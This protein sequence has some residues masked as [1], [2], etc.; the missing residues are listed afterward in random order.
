MIAG[1]VQI[2]NDEFYL[3]IKD[4][5]KKT[6]YYLISKVRKQ[7]LVD[8]NLTG[9]AT[10]TIIHD[11]A[12]LTKYF[13]EDY[14]LESIIKSK[15]TGAVKKYGNVSYLEQVLDAIYYAKSYKFLQQDIS[16]NEY[17]L[18]LGIELLSFDASNS[19]ISFSY[20]SINGIYSLLHLHYQGIVINAK[21][22]TIKL[23]DANKIKYY[24]IT[25]TQRKQIMR[26]T[27]RT[28]TYDILASM[29]DMTWY[30]DS[31]GNVLKNY[32]SI[33][34]IYEFET[35]VMTPLLLEIIR[36]HNSNE[37]LD[38]GIDTET[39]G[40]NVYNLSK[41]NDAKDHTVSLQLSWE[42][43][44]GVVMFLDMEHFQNLPTDYVMSRLKLLF[45][46]FSG[47]RAVE[48][49]VCDDKQ[50][51]ARM[52]AF[53][54]SN[55]DD[56]SSLDNL[57]R[58]EVTIERSWICTLGHNCGFDRRAIYDCGAEFWFDDDTLQMLF[59]L[60]PK[61]VRGNNKL[62][63]QTRKIFGHETPELSDVLG[64]GNEDKYKYLVDEEVACIYGCA[65][66]DYARKLKRYLKKI[67]S[68]QMYR[69]YKQQD[70]PLINILPISEYYGLF[71]YEEQLKELGVSTYNDIEILKK[72]V[73][74]YVGAYM[75]YAQKI[76]GLDIAKQLGKITTE[77]QYKRAVSEIEID[78]SAVYEF[79]FKATELRYV[80]YDLLKY[81]ILAYTEGAKKLP[82]I[83]KYVIKK[84]LDIP[85]KEG[86]K[87]RKL[88][89][90]ILVTGADPAEYIRLKNGS[91]KDKKKAEKMCLI[92]ADKFNEKEYPLALI[93][94]KY[95][96]LN[97]EYT[98]YYKPMLEENLEGKIFKS[99]SM[100]RIET[101]R[102]SNPIQ[103]TK[104][105][106]KALVRSYTDDYYMLD[107]DM[108]QVE[109]RIMIS[110]AGFTEMIERMK[111]PEKDFHKETASVM[112]Q[113]EAYKVTAKERKEA[114][115]VSF[116]IPYGL[117]ERSLCEKLFNVVN[118][119]TLFATRMIL[120]N[121]KNRN[122]PIVDLLETARREALTPC[123]ITKEQRDLMEMYA[124]DPETK[125]FLIDVNGG[126]I[127]IPVG[128]VHNPFGFYRTF[129]LSNIG[130]TDGDKK[131]RENAQY[132]GAEGV[133]R[134]A[135]GNYPI[136][137]FAA[138]LFRI[139]LT[140]FYYLCEEEGI[141]LG[142][143]CIWHM[144][145]H[146]E[147]LCSIHKSIHPIK[148]YKLVK[149]AC[150]ITMREHTNYFVGINIGDN[151]ADCKD[152]DHEAPV[153][154]VDRMIKL[155]DSGEFIPEKTD[156]QF[157]KNGDPKQGYW[158]DHPYDFIEPLKEQYKIERIHE[159]MQAIQP[160]LDTGVIDVAV[161]LAKFDN[162][163][164]RDYMRGLPRYGEVDKGL[165]VIGFDDSGKE[166]VDSNLLD[167]LGDQENLMTWISMYYQKPRRVKRL[168]NTVTSIDSMPV[169]SEM[170]KALSVDFDDLFAD[171]LSADTDDYYS[172][173]EG[174]I[175]YT[176]EEAEAEYEFASEDCA[177]EID[178]S[179]AKEAKTFAGMLVVK[180][181]YKYIKVLNSTIKIN[182]TRKVV[183]ILKNALRKYT[184][185][186]EG[187][188]IIFVI[189]QQSERW[190]VLNPAYDLNVIDT[191]VGKCMESA[192]H[193]KNLKLDKLELRNDRILIKVKNN[194]HKKRV[195]NTLLN[196]GIE[197]VLGSD[198]SMYYAVY[199]VDAFGSQN[200][201]GYMTKSGNLANLNSMLREV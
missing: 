168:D 172:F 146:D 111:D 60:N 129:D 117:G 134:R 130:Q 51:P 66:T 148:I 40:L 49:Y 46:N 47:Q 80:L 170:D 112:H 75:D 169:K 36:A 163:T 13:S 27:I 125:E 4:L 90:D 97:K 14:L 193:T 196:C 71:T 124:K 20:E 72:A 137:S 152:D 28:I 41:D 19:S 188:R 64:K 84:L 192:S 155:Y 133:I 136:Q 159:V 11:V 105:N 74:T 83:D 158:F 154:F 177:F 23:K 150:M 22:S 76:H 175:R 34:T 194:V 187:N 37:V 162:Y 121:W 63:V 164:V 184:H 173:D 2:G 165:A 197:Q 16:K 118:E 195:I 24:D 3:C 92:S 88:N 140:R 77:E 29:L 98:S 120:L 44:Q 176:V 186:G 70:V 127:P 108:S 157:L 114:K 183:D 189:G 131:R 67:T 45:E 17:S 167:D 89:S 7:D 48:Y 35:Q 199:L 123:E 85:R 42:D 25:A 58:K 12:A 142:K 109:Y 185:S 18:N 62:K 100:A 68:P 106:L 107:F 178:Y 53:S 156:P 91:D 50:T 101:R 52:Q 82:K 151:W 57:M 115:T 116:G 160:D 32:K 145:I 99:Y 141:H 73:Y 15:A 166:V 55:A 143:E 96:E 110:L 182:T 8:Y 56:C 79:E 128:K 5:S 87:T 201:F 200:K 6:I 59:N 135:A 33:K 81:P 147:L 26:A 30:K 86:S 95:S 43:D 144:L 65:D 139:I 181:R 102:I 93:I 113:K 138:E 1:T 9:A 103:T 39:T 153:I 126:Y 171:E 180:P 179:R 190:L 132:T 94:Q 21:E 149:K 69:R 78:S 191:I 104:G 10:G 38:V 31:D 198:I 161:L 122:A 119:Q 54:D 61:T 174:D